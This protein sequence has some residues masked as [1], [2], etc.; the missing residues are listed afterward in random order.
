MDSYR[1]M[2]KMTAALVAKCLQEAIKAKAKTAQSKTVK[3]AL[4][5]L[6]VQSV[7]Q[8]IMSFSKTAAI[9]VSSA[10]MKIVPSAKIT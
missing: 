2:L 3:P 1:E 4:R 9:S 7:S 6:H 5:P 8:A 10:T